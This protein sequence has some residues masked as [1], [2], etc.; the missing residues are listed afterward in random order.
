MSVLSC[1]SLSILVQ[2]WSTPQESAQY[3]GYLMTVIIISNGTGPVLATLLSNSLGY[4]GTLILASVTVCLINLGTLQYLP[5]RLNKVSLTHE[6]GDESRVT[7]CS[8]LSN[9]TIIRNMLVLTYIS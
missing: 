9:V 2:Q 1:T 7:Y 6:L 4:T 5:E 8:I 3:I